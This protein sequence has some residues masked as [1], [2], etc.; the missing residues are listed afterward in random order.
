MVHCGEVKIAWILQQF[1]NIKHNILD[2]VRD[3]I[4]LGH[5]TMED[6]EKKECCKTMDDFDETQGQN[7]F[8]MTPSMTSLL[9]I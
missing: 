2:M 3:V 8:F 4:G 6:F 7:M 1:W 5:E 9:V